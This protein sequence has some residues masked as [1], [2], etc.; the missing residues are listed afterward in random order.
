M[1]D[2]SLVNEPDS[3]ADDLGRH[4]FVGVDTEFMREKT[5][6]AELC[7]VQIAT[8]EQIYCVDPLNGH[9]MSVF[10]DALMRDTWVVHSGRQDIEVI[11]QTA[12]RMPGR[13]F[14]TQI[15]AGLLGFAPQ[16]GYATLVKEL[17]DVEIDK[18][19]TR[20]NWTRRPLPDAY[21]HY[22][23]EDVEYLLPALNMLTEMLEQ[24]GRLGWAEEDSAQLL[25]PVLYDIDPTL[26]IDR[27]KG[28]RK[29][30]GRRR[31]AAARLAAWRESEALRSNRPRQWIAKDNALLEVATRLPD[32]VD[33]LAKIDGLP[34]G[35]VRRS[36]KAIL[37]AVSASADDDT[38]YR[39]PSSPSEGQKAL[40]NSIQKHVA[41]CAADLGLAAETVASKRDLTAVIMGGDRQSKVLN[42]WRRELVGENLLELM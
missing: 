23:A 14:D 16:M 20:A 37:A 41:E 36:G 21:L 28:A 18:S 13:L 9:D 10:W 38:N 27:M 26:A 33:A 39:P 17:F 30:R 15:A 31:A 3:I 24:K 12:E 19:H 32:N 34:A 6:F 25:D 11:Y 7:L 35:L 5:F 8:G 1:L 40:L 42:G 22:A 4:D 29:L 2:Y